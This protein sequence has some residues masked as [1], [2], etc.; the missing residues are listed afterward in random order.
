MTLFAI[1]AGLLCGALAGAAHL[2]LTWARARLVTAGRA[3]LAWA[4]FPL[5]LAVVGAA[6]YGAARVDPVAAWAFVPGLFL[7]RFAVLR[8]VRGAA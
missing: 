8:R 6:L 5:G 3:G 4:T 7:T 2:G 1:A